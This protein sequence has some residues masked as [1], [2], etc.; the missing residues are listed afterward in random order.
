VLE[1]RANPFQQ[2]AGLSSLYLRVARP[3]LDSAPRALDLDRD[4]AEAWR[5]RLAVRLTPSRPAA[6]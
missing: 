6:P 3:I 1:T 2:R 4:E 5:E